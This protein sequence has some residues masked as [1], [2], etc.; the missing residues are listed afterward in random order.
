MTGVELNCRQ[1]FNFGPWC[2]TNII[3]KIVTPAVLLMYFK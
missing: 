3:K 1:V 2:Y